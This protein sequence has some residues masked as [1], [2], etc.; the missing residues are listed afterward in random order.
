MSSVSLSK[1]DP[2][3]IPHSPCPWHMH[4]QIHMHTYAHICRSYTLNH[5]SES[6]LTP[7]MLEYIYF[8]QIQSFLVMHKIPLDVYDLARIL[9]DF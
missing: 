9:I 3:S 7:K 1:H 2:A 8:F 5:H 6:G 4:A